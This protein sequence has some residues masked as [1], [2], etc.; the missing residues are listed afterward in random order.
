MA[1]LLRIAGAHVAACSPPRDNVDAKPIRYS[2]DEGARMPKPPEWIHAPMAS[3]VVELRVA[4]GE[5]VRA[6]QVLLVLDAMKMEHELHAEQD[7]QIDE[8]GVRV[9]EMVSEGD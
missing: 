9:G 3:T 7:G 1:A 6:G 4:S 2:R 5:P 8:I